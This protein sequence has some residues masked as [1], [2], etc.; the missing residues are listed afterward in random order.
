M[1]IQTSLTGTTNK[2]K[3][4][5]VFK[6]VLKQYNRDIENAIRRFV[7]LGI[8]I[9]DLR[10]EAHLA[11]YNAID[12]FDPAK[13]KGKDGLRNFIL[14]LIRR[15]LATCVTWNREFCG[16]SHAN[17]KLIKELTA[18]FKETFKN[19]QR[20]PTLEEIAEELDIPPNT[21]ERILAIVQ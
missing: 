13:A 7:G 15:Q 21:A 16:K 9:E 1:I 18:L 6:D 20:Q 14:L 2:Q 5:Q 8:S 10:Q 19:E 4:E 17:S 11:C 12:R 3:Q